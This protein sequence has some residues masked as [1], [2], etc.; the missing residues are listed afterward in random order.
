M[1]TKS[2][3][4]GRGTLLAHPIEYVVDSYTTGGE[5]YFDPDPEHKSPARIRVG[6]TDPNMPLEFA[7]SILMH[8]TLEYCLSTMGL[9]FKEDGGVDLNEFVFVLNHAQYSRAVSEAGYECGR[10]YSQF[11]KAYVEIVKWHK[12]GK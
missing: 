5:F 12:E 8:E 2:I 3:I 7:F 1:K 4:I 11:K 6:V 10:L 9:R